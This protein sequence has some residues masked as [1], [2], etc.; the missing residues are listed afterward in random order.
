MGFMELR[1]PVHFA[2][3]LWSMGRLT[4]DLGRLAKVFEI[5]EHMMRMRSRADEDEAVAD[6]GSAPAGAVALR[7]RTRLTREDLVA[8]S[9]LPPDT[10]GGAY[11]ASMRARGLSLDDIP[12][13][14]ARTDIEYVVA[15]YYETHDLWHVL[16]GFDT[17]PA[18][19]VGLLLVIASVMMNT[20]LY[21]YEDRG[22][23]F[24]AIVRGWMLGKQAKRLA[25]ID[26]RQYFVRP[27]ADV[28][29][30]LDLA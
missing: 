12:R 4:G 23:R 26:W 10:L 22:R 8:A 1:N 5:N 11:G 29:R 2:R 14:E 24:D 3:L 28:R 19:E 17:D 20:A 9:R 25:G 15:H 27:L 7:A 16:T 6:F 18:G 13:L 30:E 21:A